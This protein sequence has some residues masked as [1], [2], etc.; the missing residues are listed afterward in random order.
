MARPRFHTRAGSFASQ[1]PDYRR[2]PVEGAGAYGPP[3]S[4]RALGWML[5]FSTIALMVCLTLGAL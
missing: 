3:R 4:A 5:F 1:R 2:L